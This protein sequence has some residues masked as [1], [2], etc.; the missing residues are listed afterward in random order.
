MP[1]IPPAPASPEPGSRA[2]PKQMRVIKRSGE[3]E[4]VK[5]EKIAQRLRK[6][7]WGLG[8]VD[9]ESIV[10]AVATN[11]VDDITTERLDILAAD[12]CISRET[13][14]PD[15]GTLASRIAVSNLH[16]MT[17]DSV[18]E[19]FENLA[20]IVSDAFLSRVR[21]HADDLQA[22]MCYSRDYEF[23]YF[24]IETLKKLYCAKRDGRSIER[25]QHMY[26]RVSLALCGASGDMA[27]VKETYDMMSTKRFTHASPTLFNAGMRTQQLSSCF[28]QN[29][30][31]SLEDIFG[32]IT[33]SA[34]ISKYGGGLGIS[35]SDV[36][37]CGAPIKGTNGQS[38]GIIPLLKVVNSVACYINQGGKRKGSAAIY[39]EPHHPD[40]FEF[41]D[42][43]RPGGD[44]DLRCRDLFLALWVSDLFMKRV[45]DD[46]TWSLLD[47]SLC[48][49]LSECHGEAYETLYE[50][51]ERQGKASR[52]VGA[53]D[54]WNAIL[55]SQIESGV[56]YILYKDHANKKSNQSSLG[57]LKC[58]NL[59]V[60][61][62]TKILTDAGYVPIESLQDQDVTV[63]NGEEFS[64]TT[65]RKTGRDQ[66]LVRVQFSNGSE[67]S[68]TPYHKFYVETG[69]RPGDRSVPAVSRACDLRIGQKLIRWSLP[70]DPPGAPMP[71]VHVTAIV[72]DGERADTYCFT[73]PKRGMG[74]FNGILAGNCAEIIQYTSADEIAVCTLASVGLPAFVKKRRFDFA[75]LHET[76][77]VAA[78]NLDDVIDINAY[79]TESARRSS[80]RHRPVGIGIQGLA[81]VFAKMRMPFDSP[82]AADLN[83]KIAAVVYHAAIEMSADMAAVKGHYE[84]YPGSPASRGL[85]QYDLWGVTSPE[86]VGGTLDWEALKARVRATG[87]RN[88]LCV[89]LMPTASTAQVFGNNESFEP[90][91]SLLYTRRTLAGEFTVLN[92]HLVRDLSKAGLW[93][94]AIKNAIVRGDGS[95]QKIREI[96]GELKSLY[97][98]AWELPQRVLVDQAA[99]RGPYV[100]QSQSLNI[101]YERPT[102]E[103]LTAMHMHGWKSGLKTGSYYVRSKPA[104]NAAR[105]TVESEECVMCSS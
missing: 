17:S 6:L 88:S 61:G 18:L 36:R 42:L 22:M 80:M 45:R 10:A 39:I 16:K 12:L 103:K 31:D 97:K 57:T 86:T 67:I 101:F 43:K 37:S 77:R 21:D 46:G 94:P 74:M 76:V 71:V 105:V 54:L 15:Y 35:V 3:H 27:R 99:A 28:L 30:G 59:C 90:F 98:T 93:T 70:L 91:T 52:T 40:V 104:T 75:A 92:R 100:C 85:L 51:F 62:E 33:D 2:P 8:D 14:H 96:P 82:E 102:F 32:T 79:P 64:A 34:R 49:G 41:L 9:V 73:E 4:T 7:C 87:L 11:M 89:A 1:A 38:D 95:V 84:T 26:I 60:A 83:A 68:C 29:T 53:R 58:S 24:G 81:D 25:P 78:R 23:D 69:S 72:D 48:P 5:F 63:W 66:P 55:R 44:E 20:G 50:E 19:T 47:P 56:P 13:E 65:V